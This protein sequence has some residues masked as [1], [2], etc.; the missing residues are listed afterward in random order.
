MFVS[1]DFYIFGGNVNT[2]SLVSNYLSDFWIHVD[3][4][5]GLFE[6]HDTNRVSMVGQLESLFGKYDFMHHVIT[7]MEDEGNNL[8]SMVMALHES[9]INYQTLK[10]QKVYEGMCFGHIMFKACQYAMNDEKVTNDLKHVSV[11]AT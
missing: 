9:V 5:V 1:F 2:F 6:V 7:F 10:L 11:K 8:T 4:I 3:V